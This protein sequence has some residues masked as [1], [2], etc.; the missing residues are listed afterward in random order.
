[1]VEVF[2]D[3]AFWVARLFPRDEYHVRAREWGERCRS[4]P[5]VTTDSVLNE[6]GAFFAGMGHELRTAAT[7]LIAALEDDPNVAVLPDTREF[8]RRARNLYGAR[9]DKGYSMIDCYSMV[10]MTAR[11]INV[12]LTTDHHFEQEGFVALM[13]K[14]V[15]EA[16]VYL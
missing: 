5:L 8:V 3:T 12:A 16:D 15:S 6:V 2:V 4:N 7:L 14:D 9:P 10:V 1:M 13:R 11:G